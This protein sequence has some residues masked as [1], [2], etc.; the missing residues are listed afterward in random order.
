MIA[1][2]ALFQYVVTYRIKCGVCGAQKEETYTVEAGGAQYEPSHGSWRVYDG[3]PICDRHTIT[4]T[5][6]PE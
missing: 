6:K 5:D 4:I 2:R 1:V 3:M